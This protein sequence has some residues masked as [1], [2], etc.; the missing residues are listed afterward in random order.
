MLIKTDLLLFNGEDGEL[1][2]LVLLELLEL[3]DRVVVPP[4][5]VVVQ[6]I[7]ELQLQQLEDRLEVELELA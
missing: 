1:P 2:G 6:L 7:V 3:G 5:V 4:G